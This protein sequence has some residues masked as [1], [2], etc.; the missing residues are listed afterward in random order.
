MDTPPGIFNIR[1]RGMKEA[2]NGMYKAEDVIERITE[3]ESGMMISS[4]DMN[5]KKPH[6]IKDLRGF[7][8]RRNTYYK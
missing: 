8:G 6:E 2:G 5:L 4:E 3:A 7:Y 1:L